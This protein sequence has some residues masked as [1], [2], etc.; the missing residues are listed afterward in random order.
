[1][2]KYLITT[3]IATTFA[4][5]A[6][7]DTE[8]QNNFVALSGEIETVIAEGAND[9]YGATTSFDLGVTAVDGIAAAS[10]DFVTDADNDLTLDEWS[11]GTDVAGATVSFGDQGNIWVDTEAGSTIEDPAIAGVSLQLGVA[12]ATVAFGFADITTDVT[13]LANVQAGYGL[14]LGRLEASTAFDYNLDSKEWV[15][16]TRL[17]TDG[18]VIPGAALGGVVSYGSASETF[19]FEAD[20]TVAG[21]TGYLSGDQDDMAQHVGGSYTYDIS[22]VSLKGALDYD[23]ENEVTAPSVTVGFSF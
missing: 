15:T 12:G 20:V 2:H 21:V 10:M 17:E 4:S 8:A 9:K 14:D 22:G 19:G 1:M 13:D 7:A 5:G 23:I 6:F 16:A 3:A 18:A 11:I